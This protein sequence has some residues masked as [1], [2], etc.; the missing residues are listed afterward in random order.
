MLDFSFYNPT[1]IVFGKDAVRQLND[2]V[3][4]QARVLILYGGSSALKNGTIDQV[5][6]ALGARDIQEFGGI[7]ANPA[8]ETLMNAVEVVRSENRDFLLAVGGGSVIDGTKFVSAASKFEGDAWQILEQHGANITAAIPFGT[9]LTLPA[10]GSEMNHLAV[11]SRKKTQQKLDF[12]SELVF[13]QFSVLDPTKTETLPPRQIANGIADAFSH[14]FEQYMTYPINA[15]PQDRMAEGLLKTLVELGANGPELLDYQARANLM[16]CSTM[17]LNGLMG[18]GVPQDW[19]T[20]MIGH[21][22]TALHNI[23]HAR[24]LAIVFPANLH[25]RRDAKR[26]KLLQYGERVWDI[27]EGE[28]EARID[29]AILCTRGFFERLGLATS[30]SDYGLGED[31]IAPIL[32]QLDAH[33]MTALGERGDVT[34]D[35]TRKILEAAL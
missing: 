29:Q 18:A 10:T 30:L 12:R 11:V 23:D 32:A 26:E 6:A 20:H 17:A 33:G 9:V 34:L 19:S 8:F 2:L 16:W 1:K 25:I 22:L 27:T 24:T 5:R 15:A 31:A 28:E 14:I 21:E 7:E 35:V 3:P 4:K 13:P